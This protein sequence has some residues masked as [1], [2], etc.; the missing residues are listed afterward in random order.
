MLGAG[1]SG[2][3]LVYSSPIYQEKI[4]IALKKLGGRFEKLRFVNSGLKIWTTER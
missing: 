2:Y 3:L 4:R 1:Q